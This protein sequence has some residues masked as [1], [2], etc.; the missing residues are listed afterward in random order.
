[1]NLKPQN[2]VRHELIGLK[3]HIVAS[4]DPSH[5]C[6]DGIII[7]ESKELIRLETETGEI[8]LPKQICLLELELPDGSVVRVDGQLLRGRPEERMKK[9]SRR[10]W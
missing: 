6:R 5:V 10:R 3:A 9:H 8:L 1:M 4:S 2:L 7:G